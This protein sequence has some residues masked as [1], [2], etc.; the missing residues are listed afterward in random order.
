MDQR[1]QTTDKVYKIWNISCSSNLSKIVIPKMAVCA[2]CLVYWRSLH[3]LQYGSPVFRATKPKRIQPVDKTRLSRDHR[4]GKISDMA[5]V[6]QCYNKGCGQ[7]YNPNENK[8][9]R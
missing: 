4:I 6:I 7:K 2:S 3:G 9:G 5:V 8:D 1:P